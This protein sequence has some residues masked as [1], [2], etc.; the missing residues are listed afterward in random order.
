ME[1]WEIRAEVPA[2]AAEGTELALLESG[3]LGWS[4]LEDAVAGR[5]W[6]VGIFGSQAEAE[7]R[8]AALLPALP[9]ATLGAATPGRLPDADWANSYREHFKSWTFGR[10]HWVPVWERAAFRLPP[11]HSVLWLDPGLAFGTGNHETTRLCIERLVDFEAALAGGRAAAK[12]ARVVDAGCGSGIL[13]LSAV[14]LGFRDVSGFDSDPEAVR[15]S[16][17]NAQLNGLSGQVRFST[18]ALPTGLGEA[19]AGLVLANIQA[20]VLVRYAGELAA[21]VAPGGRLVL[22]GILATEI[23]SVRAA[24]ASAAPGWAFESRILG[25]WCDACLRRPAPAGP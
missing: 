19:Q 8:W 15:V 23:A 14:L 11:G 25:E 10:L 13:A 5:A 24:F 9:Q 4:L 7:S 6:I 18:A 12:E 3:F 22:S 1:I 21:A 20:D 16:R 17:A 2:A